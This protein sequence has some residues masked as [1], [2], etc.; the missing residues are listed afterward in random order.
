MSSCQGKLHQITLNVKAVNQSGSV[1]TAMPFS[2][3]KKQI[4]LWLPRDRTINILLKWLGG[5]D[6]G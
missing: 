3:L 5:L 4:E 2:T 6:V 1:V